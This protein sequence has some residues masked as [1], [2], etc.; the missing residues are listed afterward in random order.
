M[1]YTFIYLTEYPFLNISHIA[2][3]NTIK[4]NS[5]LTYATHIPPSLDSYDSMYNV[6]AIRHYIESSNVPI[7]WLLNSN[8][9]HRA[10]LID[11]NTLQIRRMGTVELINKMSI[12][13]WRKQLETMRYLK[14]L[15]MTS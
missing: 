2:E 6:S 5:L 9:I 3:V 7:V 10:M 11:K 14:L 15:N 13:H 1:E 12:F 8:N 4:S